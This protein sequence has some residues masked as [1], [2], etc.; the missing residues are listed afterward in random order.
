MIYGDIRA[1]YSRYVYVME[2]K[3]S[4]GKKISTFIIIVFTIAIF[5]VGVRW[6]FFNVIKKSQM[7]D[8]LVEFRASVVND[9]ESGHESGTY[10]VKNVKKSDV[11]NINKYIDSAY[12]TVD[13]YRIII[14]SGD[15]LAIQFNFELSDNYYVVRKYLYGIDIPEDYDRAAQIYEVVSSFIYKYIKKEMTDFDKELA[16]HDYIV[17]NCKYGYPESHDDAYTAY[18][19]LVLKQ[20][21]CDGYAEAF[22]VLMSCLGIDCDIVVGSTDEGL[23]AWN[24]VKLGDDW[25]NID[26]TWDDSL[27]DM[28]DYVKHTYVN[29]NDDILQRT[30]SW[31][32][33]FYRECTADYY[34]FYSK[35][36]LKYESYDDY[37]KRIKLQMGKNKVIEAA[38]RTD[39]N[40]FDLS[41]FYNYGNISS[42]N[43]VI[44]D[45][46]D[47]K[48]IIVYL[49]LK[50]S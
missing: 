23:H 14:E 25:Y 41:F 27:P 17:S 24:Q 13:T 33:Q 38:V 4:T 10:Y 15:Y 1:I 43:Y 9:M 6:L 8:G 47:Y 48:V 37:V 21:V 22:L 40:T 44:E 29:V 34:N 35:R 11:H 28:G 45:F 49:N 50:R 18:G 30:H 16:V 3:L 32:K 5:M 7:L 20:S 2:G 46:A 12:G 26:L 19:A 42:L 36:F 39:E 31:Q